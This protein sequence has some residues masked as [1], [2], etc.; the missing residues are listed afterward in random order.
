MDRRGSWH[1]LAHRWDYKDGWPT[2]PA[3]TMP[4]LVSGVSQVKSPVKSGSAVAAPPSPLPCALTHTNHRAVGLLA[5][6]RRIMSMPMSMCS[7]V[8]QRTGKTGFSTWRS[9]LTTH[10]SRSR[11]QRINHVRERYNATLF[12]LREAAPALQC[13]D[14][15]A[16]SLGERGFPLLGSA[17]RGG[18]L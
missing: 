2:N 9:S 3:Q 12:N 1:L 10:Q 16:H 6:G 17:G 18:P 8:S 15:A 4:V 7:T 13:P 11:L 14:G 5:V